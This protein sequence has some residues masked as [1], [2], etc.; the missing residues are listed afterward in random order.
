MAQAT[1]VWPIGDFLDNLKTALTARM[2]GSLSNVDIYTAPVDAEEY[3]DDRESIVLGLDVTT[4]EDVE[5][6]RGPSGHRDEETNDVECQLM[7]WDIAADGQTGEQVAKTVRDRALLIFGQVETEIRTNYRQSLSGVKN[8]KIS[9]KRLNQGV[10]PNA[11]GR[12]RA[13]V[14]EFHIQITIR[15]NVPA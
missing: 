15:T 3:D 14:I 1:A 13:C 12:A 11:D 5:A 10:Y 7:A 4:D 9:Y 8:C 6:M 2:T